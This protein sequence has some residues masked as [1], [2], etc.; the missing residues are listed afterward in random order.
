[1]ADQHGS[2][3]AFGEREC[4]IQRRHQKVIEVAPSPLV[5]HTGNM[6]AELFAASIKAAEAIGYIGAGTVEFLADGSGKFYFLEMNTRLQV[7]HPVTECTTGLDLVRLQLDVANG[8]P[9]PAEP[10]T[11]QGH[12]IEV[13]LYAEDPCE[14]WQPQSGTVRRLQVPGVNVEFA[15]P[16]SSGLRL[17]SGVVDGSVVGVFYDPM[18]AKLISW[19]PTRTE[20][21]QRL[22]GGLACAEIHGLTT[23]RDLLVR[24]LRHPEFLAGDTDTAF[25]DRH[26]LDALAEPLAAK[27]AVALSALAAALAAAAT[28]RERSTVLGG[29]PSGWRNVYSQPQAKQYSHGGETLLVSYRLH[30]G[31]LTA[32]GHDGVTLV[33]SAPGHVV[34]A[35]DGVRRTFAVRTYPGLVCVDSALGPVALHTV[36]RL[37]D[38][39]AHRAPGSLLAPMPGTVVRLAVAVGDAVTQGQPLLWLEAMKMEHAIAAP[40][41]GI[42]AEL[43]VIGGQQVEVG[44][45]LAVVHSE[46]SP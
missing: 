6:R 12:S 14:G 36:E 41:T 28:N 38:P 10:P 26:G 37:A 15:V 43:P 45:V 9:L 21:A 11:T 40:A 42:V 32:A 33:S 30:R 3:W 25:F 1:M 22:A 24:V 20:A 39:S 8:L 19:A 23:N 4:S 2:V 5:E 29:L 46:E 16:S 18:L 7:E 31:V 17:D 13:R 34:L 27:E 44:A 35:V